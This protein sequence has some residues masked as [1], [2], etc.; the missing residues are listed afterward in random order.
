MLSHA[1]ARCARYTSKPSTKVGSTVMTVYIHLL[2]NTS[3]DFFM[4]ACASD[5]TDQTVL[6]QHLRGCLYL[7]V[8]LVC[9][10]SW[11]HER[12]L[13]VFSLACSLTSSLLDC[14]DIYILLRNTFIFQTKLRMTKITRYLPFEHSTW[15]L[16]LGF[17]RKDDTI[18]KEKCCNVTSHLAQLMKNVLRSLTI[19]GK[20]LDKYL[21]TPFKFSEIS[22][23][24]TG[25][26][27]SNYLPACTV[28]QFHVNVFCLS[29][30]CQ[31]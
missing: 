3:P 5:V 19:F 24:F 12:L 28:R 21:L 22:I 1:S 2:I 8:P 23:F 29:K 4:G 17:Y 10:N 20:V 30:L 15:H 6:S 16:C 25:S 13:T 27:T 11:Q 18:R 14:L 26:K 7:W 9:I 31:N